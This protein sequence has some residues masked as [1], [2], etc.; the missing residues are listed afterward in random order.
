MKRRA[1]WWLLLVVLAVVLLP[2]GAIVAVAVSKL[3]ESQRKVRRELR[4]AAERTIGTDGRKVPPDVIDALGKVEGPNWKL[5]ARSTHPADEALG[6][7]YGP[8]QL[9][10]ATARANGFDGSMTTLG[11]DAWLSA[12][13]TARSLVAGARNAQGQVLARTPQTMED[14]SAWWNAGRQSAAQLGPSHVTRTKY[15]P[16][17]LAALDFVK[18]NPA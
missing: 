10:E 13:W 17:A 7:S 4:A 1:W 2:G 12:E 5:G 8:T 11:A 14:A 3:S 15:I 6:G 9:S 18:E 16:A